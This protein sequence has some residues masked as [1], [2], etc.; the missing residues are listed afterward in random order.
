M[1]KSAP[2]FLLQIKPHHGLALKLIGLL[3]HKKEKSTKGK[4]KEKE[5]EKKK[6]K[7]R[8]KKKKKDK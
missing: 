3:D 5:G 6:Q 8:R 2:S 7:R 4:G 1:T